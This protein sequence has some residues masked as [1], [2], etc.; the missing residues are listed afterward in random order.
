MNDTNTAPQKRRWPLVLAVLLAGLLYL[1]FTAEI[2]LYGVI[3]RP[4]GFS[5]SPLAAMDR[6]LRDTPQAEVIPDENTPVYTWQVDESNAICCFVMPEGVLAERMY[7]KAG[8]W[9]ATGWSS[10]LEYDRPAPEEPE[11]AAVRRIRP[12][13]LYGEEFRY[14]LTPVTPD[15]PADRLVLTFD[16]PGGACGILVPAEEG[17]SQK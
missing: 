6:L 3:C 17:G 12:S 2:N 9:Y 15:V 4:G 7:T 11:Y 14:T 5:D 8:G 10:F 1:A 13:G 16:T